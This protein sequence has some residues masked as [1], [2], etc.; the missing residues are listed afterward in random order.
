[1]QWNGKDFNEK[2]V[3]EELNNP[4]GTNISAN[5]T[6]TVPDTEYKTDDENIV[7]VNDQNQS[8]DNQQSVDILLK[9]KEKHFNENSMD[10]K[11]DF[12]SVNITNDESKQQFVSDDCKAYMPTFDGNQ[13][14]LFKFMEY[15]ENALEFI[16]Q[17]YLER[18]VE[19]RNRIYWHVT[20]ATDVGIIQKVFLD[21]QN[22]VVRNNLHRTGLY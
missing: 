22:I 9:K 10:I 14:L 16:T 19:S 8:H 6:P 11:R 20:T 15:Y 17:R 2:R 1:M 7:F 21:V 18:D 3:L 4:L 12:S 5:I 13:R